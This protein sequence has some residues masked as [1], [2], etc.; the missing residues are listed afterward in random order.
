MLD[1]HVVLKKTDFS[2]L[3]KLYKDKILVFGDGHCHSNSGGTSDGK[4]PIENYVED[5]KAC[6]LDF[7]AVVDHR[8]MRHMYLDCWDDK[9]FICGTE[10]G[11]RLDGCDREGNQKHLHYLMLFPDK[12]GLKKV[13]ERYGRYEFTGDEL[14]GV[15]RYP[16]FSPEEFCNLAKYVYSLGG[17]LTHAHPKQV[18]QSDNPLD[19]YFGDIVPLETIYCYNP[20]RAKS[21]TED[22]HDL[23]VSLLNMGKR[24]HTYG[25]SDTHSEVTNRGL[26]SMYVPAHSGAD[27]LTVWRTGNCCAG[28]IGIKMSVDSTPMG[29]STEY[30]P[31]KKLYVKTDRIHPAYVEEGAEYTF[32]ILTDR[33]VAYEQQ[34]DGTP[35]S[36]A[37]EVRERMY[38]RVEITDSNGTYLAI[39][40]PV[41]LDY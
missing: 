15:F 3:E 41:W 17:M 23:W 31:G 37:L 26:T 39:S 9:Y 21:D 12:E 8:Q 40:N 33:G 22:N 7:A 32:R 29:S 28:A 14:E 2:M 16:R 4:A 13:L 10:P 24:M 38:Y 27:V 11:L 1:T 18:M 34:F 6:N 5:L 19:Y 35:I 20:E 25:C 36:V 30:K